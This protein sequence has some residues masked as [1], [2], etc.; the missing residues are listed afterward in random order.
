MK[1]LAELMHGQD[2]I[3]QCLLFSL[4]EGGHSQRIQWLNS[5][6]LGDASWWNDLL[7]EAKY[8]RIA[9]LVFDRL[10]QAKL[11]IPARI[12]EQFEEIKQYTLHHNVL[13]IQELAR[14]AAVFHEHHIPFIVYKGPLLAFQ[15]YGDLSHRQIWDIDFFLRID[16]V[17]RAAALLHASG[18]DP[19]EDYSTQIIEKKISVD[20]ELVFQSKDR[21]FSIELHWRLLNPSVDRATGRIDLW[22]HTATTRLGQVPITTFT[23]EM[24]LFI[25]LYH[26]GEKHGW[27]ELK[28]LCDAARLIGNTP[29]LRWPALMGVV[30]TLKNKR[31]TMAGIYLAHR[32]MGAP[33]PIDLIVPMQNDDSLV[34]ISALM[35][36]RTIRSRHGLPS[37]REW[38]RWH[39]ALKE[40]RSIGTKT[41]GLVELWIRYMYEISMPE[42][43]DYTAMHSWFRR[44]N[45]GPVFYRFYRLF[46]THGIKVLNRIR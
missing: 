43:S 37:F 10:R 36:G 44:R 4:W 13:M 3:S 8:H 46:K 38:N 41:M 28:W 24:L 22:R 15:Y 12:T 9:P 29:A 27:S 18:Y 20:E 6:D 23:P 26:A 25:V 32:L 5:I 7:A 16:D 34:S 1:N 45:P 11:P 21:C 30:S 40:S 17:P 19:I 31:K 35:L 39:T 42:Y 2:R 14:V 33:L